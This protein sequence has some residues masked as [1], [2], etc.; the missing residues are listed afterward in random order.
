[1]R[2]TA[3][4]AFIVVSLVTAVVAT[5]YRR[6]TLIVAAVVVVLGLSAAGARRVSFDA[7]VLSLLPRDGRVIPAFRQYLRSF[8]SVDQLYVVFTAPADHA[9][10]EYVAEIDEWIDRLRQAPELAQVDAG[11]ADD[12]RNFSWL[13][14][15]ELLLL[16]GKPLDAALERLSSAGIATAVASRRELLALPSSQ[17]ADVVRHDPVGLTEIISDTLGST[18]P[19]LTARVAT[20]GYVSDDGRSRLVIAQPT[21]PPYDTTFS[22]ELDARLREIGT[23]VHAGEAARVADLDE[24]LP[25]LQVEFAGGHRIAVETEAVVRRESIL[26][27]VGSLA[28]IL[29]L[30]FV[31][32]RSLWLVLVGALPS[33]L[34]LLVVLGVLGFT[35]ATLSAAAAGSAAMLFGLGIDGVVLLYVAHRLAV[36]D[37]TPADGIVPAITGPSSS[38]LLGMWTTAATF[39]GLTFVDFP[40][41]Q[42]LGLLIGHAMMVCGILTLVLVPALLPRSIVASRHRLTMPRLAEWVARRRGMLLGAAGV[43]TGVL[44]IAAAGLHV[45]P[46]LDRLRSVTGAARLEERLAPMFGLPREVYVV[47]AGGAD[48]E[49]LLQA[50]E[51]LTARISIELP[52][53]GVQSPTRL[54]PSQ[55]AQEQTA[56]RIR[57]ARLSAE[58]VRASLDR[59]AEA[60]GF[61]PGSFQQFSDRLPRLL[62]ATH[63]LSYE[64]YEA[65]GLG[66]LA[67][68]FVIRDGARW[69]TATYVFPTDAEQVASLEQ[70]V[71]RVDPSQTLTGLPVV[72]RELARRFLP[73]FLKGLV[74]GT[75]IVVALVVLAF[76]QWWLSLY[77]LTPTVLGLVWAAGLL[78][79]AR[80]E[81]DLFALF[82]VVTFIGVGVDYGIHLVHRFQE[83]ADAGR[84]VSELAPVILVAAAI[85]LFGYGTLLNSSYPPLRSIGIVSAVC[86]FTLAAASVLVLPALL[87]GKRG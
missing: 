46:T 70:L 80:V 51:K 49:S 44:G 4:P 73:Q 29:P 47:L 35:G 22:R 56:A 21:R 2:Y 83:R 64:G 15:R 8:G 9:V 13:A 38:M 25:T 59:A 79:L 78:A 36:D 82:A 52:G 60:S 12:T 19:G 53:V 67:R 39:Y 40:S 27:T 61:R 37:G 66:D 17:I 72:N 23:A 75:V 54:L 31:V 5:A 74:I 34:S 57:D 48:L 26:N 7:D 58:A 85:T 3:F 50:N 28:L 81:L 71:E 62:N 10:T 14:D 43:T 30:L 18:A 86:V 16:R 45:N 1:M 87:I 11:V 6:R 42:Q 55:A 68:R 63:R 20:R 33:A 84:A 76:R 41:L 69:L 77:A 65:N 32:F 24:P